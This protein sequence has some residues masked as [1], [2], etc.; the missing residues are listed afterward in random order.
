MKS[1][2]KGKWKNLK[3]SVCQEDLTDEKT[4]TF[5]LE[6]V[7]HISCKSDGGGSGCRNEIWCHQTIDGI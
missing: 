3:A 2:G 5:R 4:C 6:G 7:G 1:E